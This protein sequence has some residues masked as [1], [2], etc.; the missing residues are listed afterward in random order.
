[1][2]L[3]AIFLG[4]VYAS[5]TSVDPTAYWARAAS[6]SRRAAAPATAASA[7]DA[8]DAGPV[9]APTAAPAPRSRR[10]VT[11][12][13]VW[14]GGLAQ[15]AIVWFIHIPKTAGSTVRDCLRA[16]RRPTKLRNPHLLVLEPGAFIGPT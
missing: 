6:A 16:L 7:P 1:M 5:Q 15:C 9:E 14:E 2:L 13:R 4:A 3:T 8:P 12:S 11:G 10:R